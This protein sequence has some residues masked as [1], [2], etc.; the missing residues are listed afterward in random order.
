[1]VI[2]LFDR[3]NTIYS[4]TQNI[5][6]I[7]LIKLFASAILAIF[8]CFIFILVMMVKLAE[9]F[10]QIIFTSK[11]KPQPEIAEVIN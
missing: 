5:G 4:M 6:M 7:Q 10:F 3:N 1:M 11:K 2:N 8:S 9:A